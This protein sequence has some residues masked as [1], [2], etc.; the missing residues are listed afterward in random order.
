MPSHLTRNVFRR[1]LANEPIVH[2]GCLR[3]QPHRSFSHIGSTQRPRPHRVIPSS[4]QNVQRR[5]FFNLN[6]F[7]KREEAKEADKD[8]GV[9]KMMELAKRQRLR[10]RMPPTEDVYRAV[11]VFFEAK[12]NPQKLS[13]RRPFTDTQ[14]QLV[15]QSLRY[16]ATSR[17]TVKEVEG[18]AD[19]QESQ[20]FIR[21]KLGRRMLSVVRR[22][23]QATTQAHVD[24]ARFLY[25]E[26]EFPDHLYLRYRA[27]VVYIET[28]CHTRQTNLARDAVLQYQQ[29]LQQSSGKFAQ[30]AWE[31]ILAGYVRENN[32]P[33]V[34]RTLQVMD[35]RIP[36][37]ATMPMITLSMQRNK[38]ADVKKWWSLRWSL[39]PSRPTH[40][41]VNDER[42]GKIL[43]KVL[44]WC[45]ANNEIETGQEIVR[46]MMASNPSKL[47]WDAVLIWAAGTKRSVD[48][49][50]RMITVME[51]SNTHVSDWSQWRMADIVTINGLVDLAISLND[52][53]MAERFIALG[54]SRNIEPDAKTLVLQMDYRLSVNDVDGALTAYKNLQ[55]KDTSLHEDVPAV[56]R[57]IVALCRSKYHD[58]DTVMNVAADLA[59]RRALFDAFTVSTLTSLHLSR[60]EYDDVVDLLNTHAFHYSSTERTGIRDAIVSITTDSSTP[61]SRA[62]RSYVILRDVFDEMQRSDRTAIMTAFLDRGRSDLAVNVFQDMR[63]HT[64]TD[65]IPTIETY[66]LAF[67]GLAK[68]RDI[69]SIEVVHNLLKIDI[70]INL[71]TY[72]YT[73]LI[74]AY[75]ACGQ[76][77][78]ALTFW[79]DIVAS[80]EG[81][82]Y[83]SIHAAFR[84]CEKSIWGHA[85][86]KK[87]WEML[88]SRSVDLD[89]DLWASYVAAL[90]GN[91]DLESALSVL[92]EGVAAGEVEVDFFVL[93]SMYAAMAGR[94]TQGDVEAYG[95][96]K[97]PKEWEKL[98][99]LGTEED[100][101]GWKTFKIDRAI[102]P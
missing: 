72:I 36:R 1:L 59:D 84:A 34:L 88:R 19:A 33:E 101:N 48:E 91:G 66:V 15:L 38:A 18:L 11:R 26:A 45:I 8:P 40:A 20:P 71:T 57:L 77:R 83:N 10:A 99:A 54:K 2:R 9:D 4:L 93:G 31:A 22:D 27:F 16:L 102:G 25:E 64:R 44:R 30:T 17:K 51:D 74:L 85:R 3:Q 60:D 67:I 21:S 23:N 28:L 89:Q 47:I 55:A 82:T 12:A 94:E 69:E 70:N 52:P 49:I 90:A 98:E 100:E 65:T 97:Y 95:K 87:I 62:W 50:D 14:A 39:R 61:L 13:S 76:P 68:L 42:D 92:E 46:E 24:L 32:E 58:F 78:T 37:P 6:I 41:D 7:S 96:E 63:M 56:N 73:S 43:A 35:G 81:P 29:S 80:R 53:Y 79:D 5:S 75:T 86:A